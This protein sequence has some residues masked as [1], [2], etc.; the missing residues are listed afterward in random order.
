LG[1]HK[2]HHANWLQTDFSA[3]GDGGRRRPD[4]SDLAKGESLSRLG[5]FLS[6]SLLLFTTNKK[7]CRRAVHGRNLE[8]KREDA[9]MPDDSDEGEQ[10]PM[11]V[12]EFYDWTSP[13]QIVWSPGAWSPGCMVERR[14]CTG[15]M[16][17]R[18]AARV[19]ADNGTTEEAEW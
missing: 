12:I 18:A 5:G 14:V 9:T 2:P 15:H 7:I 8:S 11:P 10:T 6:F 4:S 3:G 13:P 19:R 16:D 17:D 1:L